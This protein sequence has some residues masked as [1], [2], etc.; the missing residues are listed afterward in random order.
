MSEY[1][2]KIGML[3]GHMQQSV[4]DYIERGYQSGS[5]LTALL[6]NDLRETF[7]RADDINARAVREYVQYLYWYAPS[8]CWGSIGNVQAWQANGGL[9]GLEQAA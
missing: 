5:F 7:A 8:G 9:L 1:R 3:P 2:E 4:I 6:S